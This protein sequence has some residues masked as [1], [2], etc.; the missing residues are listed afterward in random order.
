LFSAKRAFS[1]V[2]KDLRGDYKAI[3]NGR[4]RRQPVRGY[5][6]TDCAIRS[7]LSR[8]FQSRR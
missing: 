7:V 3:D 1:I 8:R 2:S 5:L 6:P 4:P